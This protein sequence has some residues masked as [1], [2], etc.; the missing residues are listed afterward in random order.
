MHYQ[1]IRYTAANN[2]FFI[3]SANKNYNGKRTSIFQTN[4]EYPKVVLLAFVLVYHNTRLE[5]LEKTFVIII[6]IQSMYVQMD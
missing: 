5:I 3:T 1:L 4:V 2:V 6:C